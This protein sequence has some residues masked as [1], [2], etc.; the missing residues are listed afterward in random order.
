[1]SGVP[2]FP[3]TAGGDAG[4]FENVGD[5][6]RSGGFAVRAGDGDHAAVE[7][8]P[9]QFDFAPDGM[10]LARAAASAG[11]IC[12]HA[13]A[14][15]DQILRLEESGPCAPRSRVTPAARSLA[16]ASARFDS[17]F[18]SVA[19]TRAPC[20]AQKS[21]EAMPERA[22]PTTRTRISFRSMPGRNCLPQFQ[23][24][25]RQEADRG[26]C[27]RRQ[28]LRGARR[29]GHGGHGRRPLQG[30]GRPGDQPHDQG[31]EHRRPADHPA[32]HLS[33]RPRPFPPPGEPLRCGGGCR[34]LSSSDWCWRC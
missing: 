14:E 20:A 19:V 7:K 17:G 29:G 11:E 24:R 3:P 15:N 16:A 27:L 34:S 13:G 9:G 22:M 2:I 30:H 32:D 25:Q 33:H 10:P 1:M 23:S 8:A 4:G 5:E 6:R 18:S 26:R 21:A 28:G 12:G 31:R